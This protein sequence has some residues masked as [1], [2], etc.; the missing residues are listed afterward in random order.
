[1]KTIALSVISSATSIG[2]NTA[3]KTATESILV[4][5]PFEWLPMTVG[6]IITS[7]TAAVGIVAG[8]I[9]IWKH[10]H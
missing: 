2:T 9:G 8:L 5:F 10:F 4:Y 6:D 3:Q 1:V 7:L